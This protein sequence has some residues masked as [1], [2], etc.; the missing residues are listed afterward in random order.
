M[1]DNPKKQNEKQNF[2]EEF[3]MEFGDFNAAKHFETAEANKKQNKK[4]DC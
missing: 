4:R 2:R 3:G 1:K